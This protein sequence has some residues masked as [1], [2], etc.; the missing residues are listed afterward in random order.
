MATTREEL[1]SFHQYAAG[2]LKDGE[3]EPSL[4]DLLM[5][6]ADSRDRPAIN[7]AI[8]RCL[9]DVHA[10]RHEPARRWQESATNS[11]SLRH[12]LSGRADGRR[13]RRRAP[14]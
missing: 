3:S 8:R 4:D 9:A 14:I 5:E 1:E 6:W 13:E 7:E 2:R 10:G 12:E 11:D